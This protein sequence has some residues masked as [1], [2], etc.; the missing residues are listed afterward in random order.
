[1]EKENK[2]LLEGLEK[3]MRAEMEGYHF[4]MMAAQNTSD[5]AGRETFKYLAEEEKDHFNFLKAQ[6]ESITQN[7]SVAEGI[8]LGTPREF[9]VEHP[10]F[11]AEIRGRIGKAHYEMTALAI[12][13]QLEKSAVD[14]YRAEAK[15]ASDPTV[16]EFYTELM[17]WEGKHLEAF[18]GEM[19]T[20]QKDYWSEA[21]FDPF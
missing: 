17:N 10:I 2:R 3:A 18:L 13:I 1:M 8:S 15:A 19:D 20:L 14:F 4:Y 7:N 12:G 9:S 6:L 11:S 5:I 16:K 21:R